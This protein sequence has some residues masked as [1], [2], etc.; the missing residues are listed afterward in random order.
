[1]NIVETLLKI[2]LLGSSWVLWLLLSLSILSIGLMF[3]RLWYFRRKGRSGGDELRGRLGKLLNEGDDIGA[4]KLLRESGTF[5]GGVIA[6]AFPFRD[7]GAK[8]FA[9]AVDSELTRRRKELEAGLNF[10]GTLG[11]NAPFIGLFGTVIG[12]IVAFHELGSA[13]A[14][15]GAM[16]SVMSGIAE[17]LVA[18]GVGLFVAIPAVVAYNVAQKRIGDIEADT[19]SLGKLVSAWLE[20]RA[21]GE[22]ALRAA[23]K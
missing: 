7:G 6:A 15:A 12:V 10:L 22:N 5:D 3:E 9:D 16:G 23:G 4:E 14:R 19:L 8:A 20:K 11:N 1:V 21:R 18:T 13:A 2:A 17:A